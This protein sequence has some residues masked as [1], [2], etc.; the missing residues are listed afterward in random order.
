MPGR[1]HRATRAIARFDTAIETRVDGFRGHRNVDR[2]MYAASELGDFSLIW[3]LISTTRAMAPDREPAHAVRVAAILAIES[4]LVNGPVKSVFRR[5]RPAWE[6]ERPLRLRR[7]RTSS[8][9]SGHASAAMTA[10]GV[11]SQNDPLWPLYYAV[12]AVVAGSRVYVKI[13]HPSDV[14]A[15]AVVGIVLARVARRV[16]PFPDPGNAGGPSAVRPR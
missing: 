3:H 14:V 4:A 15:G 1:L 8:F 11:L 12:G 7:P 2:L 10:A 16:W 5:H 13:H 6:Q 9:P